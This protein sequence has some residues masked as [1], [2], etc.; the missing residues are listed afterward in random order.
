MTKNMRFSGSKIAV[1]FNAIKTDVTFQPGYL[2]AEAFRTRVYVA[3]EKTDKI[4]I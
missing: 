3:D 1:Q 4:Q 2:F